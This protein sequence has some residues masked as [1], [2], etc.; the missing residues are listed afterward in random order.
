MHNASWN[1]C[2]LWHPCL[3]SLLP[4]RPPLPR[5]DFQAA[6]RKGETPLGLAGRERA[7]QLKKLLTEAMGGTYIGGPSRLMLLPVPRCAATC[8]AVLWQE[9]KLDAGQMNP[10]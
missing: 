4:L 10:K 5:S 9:Q 3:K 8:C 7:K 1:S 6:N 2:S